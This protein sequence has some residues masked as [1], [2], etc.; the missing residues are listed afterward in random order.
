[1]ADPSQRSWEVFFEVYEALPRQG[2]G[3]RDCAVR[4]LGLCRDL[5]ASPSVLDMG[6]GV[7]GQTLHLAELTSGSII[8]ID[9]HAPWIDQLYRT[10]VER[11]LLHRVQPM[12]GDMG[13]ICQ[14][15]CRVARVG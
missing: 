14:K 9:S 7:G 4:A 10:V 6:C 3:N 5:P 13:N 1:M 8:A 2:P 15:G 12:V 11:G